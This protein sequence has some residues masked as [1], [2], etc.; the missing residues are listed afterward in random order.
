MAYLYKAGR[1]AKVAM[2]AAKQISSSLSYSSASFHASIA[3]LSWNRK[4]ELITSHRNAT[5][6]SALEPKTTSKTALRTVR[7]DRAEVHTSIQLKYN[8]CSYFF[9]NFRQ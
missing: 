8:H 4:Q 6:L 9:Q 3:K 7:T 2:L 5:I 1:A